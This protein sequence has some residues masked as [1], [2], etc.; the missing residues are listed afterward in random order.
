MA[1]SQTIVICKLGSVLLKF[2]SMPSIKARFRQTEQSS[3]LLELE[4]LFCNIYVR[5]TRLRGLFAE[6]KRSKY[7]DDI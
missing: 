4:I 3:L 2:K 1:V 7:R 5:T 6:G